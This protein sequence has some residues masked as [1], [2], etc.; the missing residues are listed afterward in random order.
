MSN[1]NFE[2][3]P[4]AHFQCTN[5][6][7]I[8][9]IIENM[10]NELLENMHSSIRQINYFYAQLDIS[11]KQIWYNQVCLLY[12]VACKLY[13]TIPMIITWSIDI[14]RYWL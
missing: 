2:Q 14:D 5:I 4:T 9:E 11:P 13:W 3:D 1:F 10:G 7:I 6:E 12:K 8:F